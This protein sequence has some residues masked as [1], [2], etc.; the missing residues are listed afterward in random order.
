VAQVVQAQSHVGSTVALH[1][2]GFVAVQLLLDAS[3]ISIVQHSTVHP[4]LKAW[5]LCRGGDGWVVVRS[6][7]RSGIRSIVQKPFSFFVKSDPLIDFLPIMMSLEPILVVILGRIHSIGGV[8]SAL[9]TNAHSFDI[10]FRSRTFVLNP[11]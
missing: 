3:F 6:R 8:V 4:N 2:A 10:K 9:V 11:H 5:L 7:P 1:A